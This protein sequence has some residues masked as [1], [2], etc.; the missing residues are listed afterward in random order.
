MLTVTLEGMP[1][2]GTRMTSRG[3]WT[4]H[5]WFRFAFPAFIRVMRRAERGVVANARHA[6]EQGLDAADTSS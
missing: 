5:G 2:G 4:H 1:N 6:L 3:V